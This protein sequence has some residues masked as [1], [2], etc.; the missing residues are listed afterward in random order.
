[1]LAVTDGLIHLAGYPKPMEEDC[2]LSGHRNGGSIPRRHASRLGQP[3]ATATKISV[4]SEGSEDVAG[5]ADEQSTQ[6][7]I[8]AFRNPELG[9]AVTGVALL[10]NEAKVR[11]DIA[12]FREPGGVID[13]EDE[14][15]RRQ[16]TNS[17]NLSGGLRARGALYRLGLSE[18]ETQRPPCRFSDGT[19]R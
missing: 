15:Q 6:E 18:P 16:R 4:R 13:R 14:A 3:L 8:S 12:A 11:S 2:Q 1:M 9:L 5:T 10:G 17:R 19:G 7:R